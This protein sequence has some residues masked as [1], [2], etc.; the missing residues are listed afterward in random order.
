MTRSRPGLGPPGPGG[1]E[2]YISGAFFVFSCGKSMEN[3]QKSVKIRVWGLKKPYFGPILGL[4]LA[5]LGLFLGKKPQKWAYFGGQIWGFLGYSSKNGL[6][7]GFL[8]I[9]RGFIYDNI[10]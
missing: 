5:I 8:G 10:I 2:G 9:F 1:G 3:G 4:F 6:F 7:F